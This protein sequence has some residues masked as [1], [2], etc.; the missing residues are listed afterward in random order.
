MSFSIV[1]SLTQEADIAVEH[2]PSEQSLLDLDVKAW[3]NL[4]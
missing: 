1:W 4:A 3:Q 2:Q